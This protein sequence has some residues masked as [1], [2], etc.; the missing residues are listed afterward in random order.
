MR[1]FS[2]DSRPDADEATRIQPAPSFAAPSRQMDTRPITPEPK[3]AEPKIAVLGP[4]L[5]FKG[6][7]SAEE[8][9]IL[10]GQIEGSIN[11][12]Q[13]VTIGTEG[14]VIGNIHAR[15]ITI[16]G[17]V[18][19]DLHASESVTVHAT[20]HLT[21]NIFAPRIGIVE[22]AFFNGRVEMT[23]SRTGATKK[24]PDVKLGVPLS[25]EETEKVLGSS[26]V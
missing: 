23:E 6:E 26:G 24:T 18:Q 3:I 9:F 1:N 12:T 19:G 13:S 21:G 4:T 22:G 15:R 5:R 16:D 10:Q 20:G 17:N 7:L 25:S 8:D 14:S 2:L 11:H